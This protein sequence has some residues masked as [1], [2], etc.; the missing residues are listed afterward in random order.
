MAYS[1]LIQNVRPK[2]VLQENTSKDWLINMKKVLSS[3]NFAD[4]ALIVGQ[5]KT[6]IPLHKAVMVQ[7]PWIERYLKI[8]T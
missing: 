4:M 5:N 2:M 6:R 7:S 8:S 3:G 1:S